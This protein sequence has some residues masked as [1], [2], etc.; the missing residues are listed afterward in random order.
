MLQQFKVPDVLSP[1]AESPSD[2]AAH[3]TPAA[4]QFAV[5][6]LTIGGYGMSLITVC[7]LQSGLA[8]GPD[9]NAIVDVNSAARR[10][11]KRARF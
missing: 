4:H 10:D 6:L 5:N 2:R 8:G 1:Q 3:P 7:R 9:E 11:G